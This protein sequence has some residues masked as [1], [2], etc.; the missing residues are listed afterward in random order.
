VAGR[1]VF[2]KKYEG[3]LTMYEED[4]MSL[5]AIAKHFGVTHQTIHIAL[6]NRGYE[7]RR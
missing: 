4:K 1:N 2:S 3:L 6:Q 5:R 7:P